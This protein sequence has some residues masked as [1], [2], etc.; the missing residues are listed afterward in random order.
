MSRSGRM[1]VFLSSVDTIQ[2]HTFHLV[3]RALIA[4]KTFTDAEVICMPINSHD[5]DYYLISYDHEQGQVQ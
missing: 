4:S 5:F 2:G 3:A 1:S